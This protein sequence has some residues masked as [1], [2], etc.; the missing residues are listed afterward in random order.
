MRYVTG[1][2]QRIPCLQCHLDR[3]INALLLGQTSKKCQVL[4]A[5]AFLMDG[6]CRKFSSIVDY[7]HRRS[8]IYFTHLGTTHPNEMDP[9]SSPCQNLVELLL[10][11]GIFKMKN[12]WQL[13]SIKVPQIV[14]TTERMDNIR[15]SGRQARQCSKEN[16]PVGTT[17]VLLCG[18]SVTNK[19]VP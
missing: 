6:E 12:Q 2:P 16:F 14:Y 3:C 8:A 9:L 18:R 19:L 4:T 17:V 1:N 13:G 10:I 15:I 7:C 11:D 5:S